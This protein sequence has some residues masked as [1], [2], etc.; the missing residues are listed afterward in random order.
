LRGG[1]AERLRLAAARLGL[2]ARRAAPRLIRRIFGSASTSRCDATCCRRGVVVSTAERD[3]ILKHR[4]AVA[5]ALAE[6][7]RPGVSTLGFDWF[8]RRPRRDADFLAG[9]SVDTRVAAGACVFLRADR[10]CA[11]HVASERE[12]GHPY[13]LKPAYCVLFPLCVEK[14]ALDLC[15]ASFTRRAECCSPVRRGS[16]TPLALF[17]ETMA[18][19]RGRPRA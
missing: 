4:R 17:A 15:R 9:R 2:D 1:A 19:L 6:S 7:P 8:A 5:R 3:A 10:L 13:A 14:N 18:R 12:A 11:V 16:R